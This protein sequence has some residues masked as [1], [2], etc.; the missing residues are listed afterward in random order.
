[1][2][3]PDADSPGGRLFAVRCSVCHTLPHPKRLDWQHWRHMLG[4]MKKRMDEGGIPEPTKTEW[5]QISGYLKQH[6]R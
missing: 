4:V 6:A 5:R 3:I 2:E 1:M